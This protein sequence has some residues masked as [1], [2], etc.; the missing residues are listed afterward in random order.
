MTLI[1][2]TVPAVPIAQPRQRHRAFT[3]RGRVITQNFTPAKHPVQA[4]KATARLAAS[5]AYTGAPLE[6]PICVV[7]TFVFPRPGRLCWKKRPMPRCWHA[8]RPDTENV[9]KALQ[10]SLTGL[11]WKDDAQI[12]EVRCKKVYASGD[13]QPHVSVEVSKATEDPS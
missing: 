7:A 13:E 4:F 8:S 10:D 1:A 2:F 12:A 3:V 6:G 11:I 9:L 5:Q